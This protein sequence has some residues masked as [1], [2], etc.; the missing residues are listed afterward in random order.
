VIVAYSYVSTPDAGVADAF[1]AAMGSRARRVEQFPGFVR[2]E[3]RREVGRSRRHVIATWW[4]TLDDLRRYLA[5]D[6][7]R[8]THQKLD[9]HV[10]ARIGKPRVEVHEVLEVSP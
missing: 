3:F 1:E 6:D 9:P 2:F 7:H 4:E 10:R 5:S 8:A